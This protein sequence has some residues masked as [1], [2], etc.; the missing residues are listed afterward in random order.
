ME[1]SEEYQKAYKLQ[2]DDAL[3]EL[4]ELIWRHYGK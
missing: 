2:M 3:V 1:Q 4:L